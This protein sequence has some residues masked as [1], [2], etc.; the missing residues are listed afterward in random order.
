MLDKTTTCGNKKATCMLFPPQMLAFFVSYFSNKIVI[1]EICLNR[2][3]FLKE[4]LMSAWYFVQLFSRRELIF[5]SGLT[6]YFKCFRQTYCYSLSELLS[7]CQVIFD[8]LYKQMQKTEQ[9]EKQKKMHNK[10]TNKTKLNKNTC[11]TAHNW[12]KWQDI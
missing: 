9:K 1:F 2:S 11:S 4:S 10:Q 6:K 5:T 7:Y 8:L 3:I 12:Q